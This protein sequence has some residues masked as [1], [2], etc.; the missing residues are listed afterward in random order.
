[1][2]AGGVYAEEW[3]GSSW[4]T[5]TTADIGG[6]ENFNRVSCPSPSFCVAVGNTA[7]TSPQQQTLAEAWNGSTWSTT[8]TTN[9]GNNDA[10][11]GVSCLSSA[12]CMAVGYSYAS[13]EPVVSEI[14]TA[15]PPTS[16][17]ATPAILQES[18]LVAELFGLNATLTNAITNS[19]VAGEPVV[20]TAGN[21]T[22]CAATTN[23]SGVATCNVLTSLADVIAVFGADGYSVSFAGDA[24]YLE[25]NGAAGLIG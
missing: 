15:R 12:F 8:T 21:T 10:L 2:T 1:V 17:T 13:G 9:L 20:F 25:S 6:D 19:P 4:S 3:N 22:L 18:P 24:S 11:D 5:M 16:L 7:G 23:A 14:Y